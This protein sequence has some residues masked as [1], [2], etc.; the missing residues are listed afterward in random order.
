MEASHKRDLHCVDALV[1]KRDIQVG[2]ME[3]SLFNLSGQPNLGIE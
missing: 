2:T 1:I 3:A